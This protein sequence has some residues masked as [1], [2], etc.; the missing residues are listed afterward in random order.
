TTTVPP[1]TTTTVPPTTTSSAPPTT[2]PLSKTSTQA[3]PATTARPATDSSTAGQMLALVNE[4]RAGAGC[5]ALTLDS[6]LTDAAQR[7]SDDMSA[8]DYFSHT[9]PEGVTFGQRIKAAGYPSPGAENIAEGS[10]TV[11]QTMRLWLNSDGHRRNI[12]NCSYAKLGVGLARDGW[13]WT[14]DFGF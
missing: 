4:E 3:K 8:R 10:S 14:Q 11:A 9:T 7:H 6:R 13:Y 1:T 12:L 2:A 5:R